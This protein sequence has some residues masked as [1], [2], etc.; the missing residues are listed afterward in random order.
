MDC[1]ID[2]RSNEMALIRIDI[3]CRPDCSLSRG[4]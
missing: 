1:I 2:G 4:C 3:S